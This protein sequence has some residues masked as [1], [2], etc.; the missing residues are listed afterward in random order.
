[1]TIMTSDL[2]AQM[3]NAVRD[4]WGDDDPAYVARL[5]RAIDA[6]PDDANIDVEYDDESDDQPS[7]AAYVAQTYAFFWL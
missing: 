1:M 6:T 7:D 4:E 5:V 2:R 3:I